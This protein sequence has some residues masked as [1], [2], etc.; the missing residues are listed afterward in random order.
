[1]SASLVGS[2]MC[3]RDRLAPQ[4]VSGADLRERALTPRSS[5]TAPSVRRPTCGAARCPAAVRR[6]L[7]VH[8]HGVGEAAKSVVGVLG[9]DQP[10]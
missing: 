9:T 5:S 1:M 6:S 8:W 10:D 7:P 3:I 4:G 2:E